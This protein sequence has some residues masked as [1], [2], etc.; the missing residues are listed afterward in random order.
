MCVDVISWS[1]FLLL[2]IFI[3][4]TSHFILSC[5]PIH[6]TYDM[7]VQLFLTSASNLSYLC[8]SAF[9]C[10]YGL[11]Y[12]LFLDKLIRERE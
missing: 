1:L 3:L 6:C 8:L 4:T 12:F 9:V 2:G 10:R 7:V 5:T 11:R